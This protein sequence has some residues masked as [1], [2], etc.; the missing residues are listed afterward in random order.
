VPES[1]METLRNSRDFRKVIESGHRE[2]LETITI[3]RLPNQAEETRIGISVGKKAGGS[4]QRNRIKRRIRE[5]VSKNAG[6]FDRKEDIVLVARRGIAKATYKD[7]ERDIRG[8]GERK[9]TDERD[10]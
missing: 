10:K 2:T 5:A 9:T 6:L 7:I 1:P 8:S 3:Y 4:V